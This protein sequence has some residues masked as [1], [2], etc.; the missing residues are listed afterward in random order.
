MT[1]QMMFLRL[2]LQHELFQQATML[3][4]KVYLL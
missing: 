3:T 2:L 1:T 4:V